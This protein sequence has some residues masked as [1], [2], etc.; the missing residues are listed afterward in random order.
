ML[1]HHRKENDA[2]RH[3]KGWLKLVEELDRHGISAV[4]VFDGDER[5]IL[6]TKLVN[7]EKL[8]VLGPH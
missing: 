3:I 8:R 7:N 4:C 2:C 1:F 6:K 5:N